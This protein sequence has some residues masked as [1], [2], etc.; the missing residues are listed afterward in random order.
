SASTSAPY[1]VVSGSPFSL[2]AGASQAVV[3]RFSPTA[4]GTFTGNVSFTSN[5]GNASPRVTG[6][7][8]SSPPQISVTP[9]SQDFGTVAVGSSANRTFTVHNNGGSTLTGSAT[10]AAPFSVS[11]GSPFSVAAGASQDVVV[12]FSP[13]TTGNFT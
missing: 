10:T 4:T 9:A 2:A 6:V 8:T 12:S 5:G 11:S 3:V 1:S 7:G 13:T